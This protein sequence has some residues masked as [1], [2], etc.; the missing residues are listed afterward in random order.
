[1]KSAAT[2]YGREKKNIKALTYGEEL[3]AQKAVSVDPTGAAARSDRE[4]RWSNLAELFP[5]L[6]AEDLQNI[7]GQVK[8][9]GSSSH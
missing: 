8:R 1:M 7:S 6:A 9:T 2:F 5:A 4:L 3:L